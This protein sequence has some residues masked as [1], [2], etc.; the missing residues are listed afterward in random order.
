M[1]DDKELIEAAII[2][3]LIGA[4]LETLINGNGKNSGLG[5][6]AGA[7]FFASLKANENAVKTNIPLVLKENNTI[8]E[9]SANGSRRT[10]RKI[11]KSTRHVPKK[12]I[13]K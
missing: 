10:I 6:L 12:F 2:G 8:Y 1:K 4:G 3:G 13:L 9:I 5:A 7:A 11:P